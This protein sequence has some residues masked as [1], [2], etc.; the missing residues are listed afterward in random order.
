MK[1][2]ILCMILG[3]VTTNVSS[4]N[5]PAWVTTNRIIGY[6][7]VNVQGF[8]DIRVPVQYSVAV[9]IVQQV[10]VPVINQQPVVVYIPYLF[11]QPQVWVPSPVRY[12]YCN[13]LWHNRN[14]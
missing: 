3:L 12:P 6:Q 5:D 13:G 1:N 10:Q 8:Q 9:P 7:Q 4:A 14:R 11:P 2:I